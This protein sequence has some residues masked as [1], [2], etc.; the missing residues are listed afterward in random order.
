IAE[1]RGLNLL[2]QKISSEHDIL[3]EKVVEWEKFTEEDTPMADRIELASVDGVIDRLQGKRA[4]EP[5][6]LV[7]EE[8]ILLLIMDNSGATYFSHSFMVDWDYSDL[9]SDFMS[10]FNTFSS[11]IFSKSIDRIRIGENTILINPIESFLACYVIKGQSYP[12]LQKLTRF[13]EAMRENPEIWQALNK[14]IKTSEILE[15]NKPPALKTVINE[16]FT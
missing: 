15:L 6:E 14:S 16:I 1:M 7:E 13:S 10:A 3:L 9:F 12:A 4:I 11:E 8:P 2:A 5:P